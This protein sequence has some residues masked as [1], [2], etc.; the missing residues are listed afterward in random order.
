RARSMACCLTSSDTPTPPRPR[1]FPCT[2][3]FRPRRAN[4]RG[5]NATAALWNDD[6]PPI[7]TSER[8]VSERTSPTPMKITVLGAGAMGS[9]VRSEEHT[10]E[11]QSR[12]NLVC[13]LL[14]E[15]KKQ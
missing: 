3:L 7:R 10:S 15:K 5:V 13:R 11:L 4:G 14:L 9:A 1:L 8:V 2:T 12:E 6:A